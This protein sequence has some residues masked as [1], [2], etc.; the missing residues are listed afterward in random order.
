MSKAR[1]NDGLRNITNRS[2][3]Q[4]PLLNKKARRNAFEEGR[5]KR[6]LSPKANETVSNE[7]KRGALGVRAPLTLPDGREVCKERLDPVV[8]VERPEVAVAHAGALRDGLGG[9][10]ERPQ[11]ARRTPLGLLSEA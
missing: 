1:F 11:V 6:S 5:L 9:A 4:T 10:P 8:L 2:S 3:D 7:V